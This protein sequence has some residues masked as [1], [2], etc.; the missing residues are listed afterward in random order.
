MGFVINLMEVNY[1]PRLSVR[2]T[3][4]AVGTSSLLLVLQQGD[5]ERKILLKF[6]FYWGRT[7]L[8]ISGPLTA[9]KSPALGRKISRLQALGSGL[10]DEVKNQR[11]SRFPNLCAA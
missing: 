2:E 9:P 6:W 1:Y 10:G 5:R 3:E 11:G 7:P 4:A 8:A